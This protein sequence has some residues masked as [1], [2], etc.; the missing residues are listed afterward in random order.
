MYDMS[1]HIFRPHAGNQR[2]GVEKVGAHPQRWRPIS[3]LCGRVYSLQLAGCSALDLAHA[4][5]KVCVNF[6]FGKVR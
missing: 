1:Q 6:Q 4:S 2:R 3:P 5:M